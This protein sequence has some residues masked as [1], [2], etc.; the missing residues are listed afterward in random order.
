M[1]V[2]INITKHYKSYFLKLMGDA[3]PEFGSEKS[4]VKNFS[5]F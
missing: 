5:I 2:V 3:L 4:A 1:K